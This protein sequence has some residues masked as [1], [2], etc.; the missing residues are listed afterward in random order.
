MFLLTSQPPINSLVEILANYIF[1]LFNFNFFP[2]S[3]F[4]WFFCHNGTFEIHDMR[5]TNNIT[6]PIL[7][8]ETKHVP[9]QF[10]IFISFWT[11]TKTLSF[12]LYFLPFSLWIGF[13]SCHGS[14][15]SWLRAE[16]PSAFHACQRHLPLPP[17]LRR[18]PHRGTFC[19]LQFP[20]IFYTKF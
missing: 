7:K 5:G 2:I 6:W 16:E 18:V 19:P 4:F 11:E 13:R 14:D 1:F 17:S 15:S 10:R 9:Y 20:S 8:S 3:F 12:S